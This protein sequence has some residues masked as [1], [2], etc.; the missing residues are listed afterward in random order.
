[1]DDAK[2][3]CSPM[4][5]DKATSAGV[6]KRMQLWLHSA[7]RLRLGCLCSHIQP[8]ACEPTILLKRRGSSIGNFGLPSMFFSRKFISAPKIALMK[9]A[10]SAHPEDRN[11]HRDR[12]AFRGAKQ[13]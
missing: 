11:A 13:V 4:G 6:A 7:G 5:N 8:I 3:L 2:C 10:L 12:T 1:M 9:R